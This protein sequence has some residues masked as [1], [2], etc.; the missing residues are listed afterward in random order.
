MQVHD[1]GTVRLK[2]NAVKDTYNLRSN[3]P[4]YEAPGPD[5]GGEC[6]MGTSMKNR[7]HY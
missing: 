7:K 3:I 6:N 4:Y 2:V 5:H 1:N